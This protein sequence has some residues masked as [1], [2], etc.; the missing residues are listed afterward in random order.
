MGVAARVIVYNEMI[1][2]VLKK[3]D[4]TILS[5]SSLSPDTKKP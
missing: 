2:L 1:G 4:K 5:F 3:W